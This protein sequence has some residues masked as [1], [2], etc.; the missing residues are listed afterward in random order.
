MPP[1]PELGR[2]VVD[3]PVVGGRRGR[4]HRDVRAQFGDQGPDAPVVGPEVV[5]PVRHAVRLVD[6]HQPGVG[7]QRGQHVVAE[8]GVVEPL[9]AD[10]QHVEVA[11]ADPPVDVGPL[12]DVGGVDGRRVHTGPLGGGHLVAHQCQQRRDDHRRS[13]PGGAQQFGGDEVHRR[14][15]PAGALHHQRPPTLHHQRLDRGPLVVAQRGAP[16]PPAVRGSPAPARGLPCAHRA[17]RV[18]LR[19]GNSSRRRYSPAR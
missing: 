10:Q 14:L 3:H 1:D 16:G 17:R 19:P 2:D 6:H 4:Q 7:G 5:T 12:G 13:V 15:S 18:R 8:V 9:R 11:A